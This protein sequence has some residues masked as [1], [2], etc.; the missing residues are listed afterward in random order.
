M[1]P[2]PSASE[3]LRL[4]ETLPLLTWEPGRL[5]VRVHDSRYGATEAHPGPEG[6]TGRWWPMTRFAHFR[7]GARRAW[8]PTLY[9]GENRLT[10]LAETVFRAVPVGDVGE[11]PRT[12]RL[13]RFHAHLLSEI[14]PRRPL[15][16]IDLRAPA[17][18]GA[19]AELTTAGEHAY[20]ETVRWAAA[21]HAAA[22]NADG[23]VWRSRQPMAGDAV[24]LWVGGPRGRR[25]VARD[26]LIAG[27]VPLPLMVAE[28]LEAVLE[29]GSALGV[30]VVPP[31]P[32]AAA[33]EA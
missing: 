20:G 9:A 23:L 5:L 15:A 17:L 32:D 8:V 2:A 30:T 12:V 3:Q 31:D 27:G 18:S 22:P 28:G 16:L 10:A 11:R 21:L 19:P 7:P 25:R 1:R 33:P 26:D 13:R 29:T 14:V 4:P 6:V 24:L